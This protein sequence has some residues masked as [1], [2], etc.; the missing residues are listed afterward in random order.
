MGTAQATASKT[1]L[2]IDDDDFSLD[3]MCM[4]LIALGLSKFEVAADGKGA[5]RVLDRL[6]APPDYLICDIYMPDMDGVEFLL[7]M[8]RR[9]YQGGIVLVSGDP[10]ILHIAQKIAKA[11]HL[12]VLGA[13]SKPLGRDTLAQALGLSSVG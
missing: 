6:P 7:E 11:H 9:N 4:A 3:A 2:V 8:H 12:N 10:Q 13:F 1:A 5:L